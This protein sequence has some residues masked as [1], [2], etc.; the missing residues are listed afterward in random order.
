MW[1]RSK[2]NQRPFNT[3]CLG[4]LNSGL[5]EGPQ[6]GT[7]WGAVPAVRAEG[8]ECDLEAVY[9]CGPPASIESV[10]P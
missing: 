2:I 1:K 10:T 4:R 8:Q 7:P 6:E 9:G 5:T 3:G